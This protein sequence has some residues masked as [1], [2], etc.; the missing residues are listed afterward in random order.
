[1]EYKKAAELF[2]SIKLNLTDVQFKSFEKYK[3]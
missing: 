3:N 1:M 2:N